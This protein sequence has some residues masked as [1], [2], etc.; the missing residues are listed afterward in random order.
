[1]T[2]KSFGKLGGGGRR[3]YRESLTR[4]LRLETL[5]KRQV[6]VGEM[7]VEGIQTPEPYQAIEQFYEML[8]SPDAQAWHDASSEDSAALLSNVDQAIVAATST[9]S[10]LESSGASTG[11]SAGS[12]AGGDGSSSL[13]G[14]I[15]S[16]DSSQWEPLGATWLGGDATPPDHQEPLTESDVP[17]LSTDHFMA[18]LSGRGIVQMLQPNDAAGDEDHEYFGGDADEDADKA[19]QP[20]LELP[21]IQWPQLQVASHDGSLDDFQPELT[22]SFST[23]DLHGDFDEHSLANP[24]LLAEGTHFAHRITLQYHS[25]DSWSYTERLVMVFNHSSSHS[26]SGSIGDEG[27]GDE[28]DSEGDDEVAGGYSGVTT[29]GD[30]ADAD[31]GDDDTADDD[32][33]EAAAPG[34]WSTTASLA[35]RGFLFVT[36]TASRG[37]ASPAAAGTAWS[38]DISTR[39][40]IQFDASASGSIGDVPDEDDEESDGDSDGESGEGDSGE[41]A[42]GAGS[43]DASGSATDRTSDPDSDSPTDAPDRPAAAPRSHFQWGINVGMN[44][45]V[46]GSLNVSSTP[47]FVAV[48]AADGT[49]SDVVQRAVTAGG[50]YDLGGGS[51]FGSSA[52]G[53]SRSGNLML[54]DDWPIRARI[55]AGDTTSGAELLPPV[56]TGHS[57]SMSMSD[58]SGGS[59]RITGGWNLMAVM[60]ANAPQSM[61]GAAFA[62]MAADTSGSGQA[63]HTFTWHERGSESD[64]SGTSNWSGLL[65]S[66]WSNFGSGTVDVSGRVDTAISLGEDG[67]IVLD[68]SGDKAKITDSAEAGG[69]N[70]LVAHFTS[71]SDRTIDQIT[72]HQASDGRPYAMRSINHLTSSNSLYYQ[73][74]TAG[75]STSGSLAEALGDAPATA[76][77]NIKWDGNGSERLKLTSTDT[78]DSRRLE[79]FADEE[80]TQNYHS[81]GGHDFLLILKTQYTDEGD[82]V[83]TAVEDVASWSGSASRTDDASADYEAN[84][85]GDHFEMIRDANGDWAAVVY[86]ATD[87]RRATFSRAASQSSVFNPVTGEFDGSSSVS[88]DSEVTVTG[89][90]INEAPAEK[91]RF[92]RNLETI[93]V[94]AGSS[95]TP[96][97]DEEDVSSE[98]DD[99]DYPGNTDPPGSVWGAA[100]SGF[101]SGFF[102]RK[103]ASTAIGLIPVVGT[104]QSA[105]ELATGYDFIAGEEADRRAAMLGLVPG[106]KGV[107]NGA[108]GIIKA[109][110]PLARQTTILGS[111][112]GAANALRKTA[113]VRVTG[114]ALADMRKAFAAAKPQAWMDEAAANASKY[115]AA[116]LERMKKGLA[117]LGDDGFPMEIHHMVPLAEGGTNAFSNF[118]FLTRTLHRLGPNYKLNHPNL[119]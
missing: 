33:A 24:N 82:L 52:S 4:R 29:A 20:K 35:R 81:V 103:N 90:E 25:A 40:S 7:P 84:R 64:E 16:F 77:A 93:F 49:T 67:Q 32:D 6:L 2:I 50:G 80:P 62:A 115:T 28:D 44:G 11:Q 8:S 3:R 102:S 1:M 57:A 12:A 60:R 61:A 43:G 119:P 42:G 65:T 106:G 100:A 15:A 53:A 92:E 47:S 69:S 54:E 46:G 97:A 36:F 63:N 10:S 66:G 51:Q 71:S 78:Y 56:G 96:P 117:P 27:E 118:Q 87:P 116:Q 34:G 114:Q 85:W 19:D 68:A 89:H 101:V 76:G 30:D 108:K 17:T 75:D 83:G 45:F 79:W 31:A 104:I 48:L 107:V 59:S 5:E 55:A 21:S 41:G 14:S 110:A 111:A 74:F 39:D 23:L 18:I 99:T 9:L 73:S 105:V 86:D 37:I 22:T 94:D 113:P 58:T 98:Y 91:N 95:F 109:A 13:G 70:F 112:A 38:I 88:G 72:N 26:D